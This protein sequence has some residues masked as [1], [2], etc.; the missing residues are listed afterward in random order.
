VLI[1]PDG[2]VAFAGDRTDPALP[3]ALTRW[4]GAAA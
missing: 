3:E 2:H 1:R 4:F